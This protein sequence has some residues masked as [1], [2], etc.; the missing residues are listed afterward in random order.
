MDDN[1]ICVIFCNWDTANTLIEQDENVK[2]SLVVSSY[3]DDD[4]AIVVSKD[5]FLQWLRGEQDG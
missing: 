3:L 4:E 2:D 1:T 5:E